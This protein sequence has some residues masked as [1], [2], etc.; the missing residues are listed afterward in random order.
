RSTS[1]G[2]A[3]V[4]GFAPLVRSATVFSKTKPVSAVVTVWASWLSATPGVPL[5]SG[6]VN[7]TRLGLPLPS[8]NQWMP[9]ATLGSATPFWVLGSGW[10][11]EWTV[12]GWVGAIAA[13]AVSIAMSRR[14]PGG[15]A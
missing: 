15:P 3:V 6:P 1:P 11:R 2:A 13:L 12:G 9:P 8:L 4:A 5:V 7:V 10:V 14:Q